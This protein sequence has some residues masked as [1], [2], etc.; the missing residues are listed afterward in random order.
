MSWSDFWKKQDEKDYEEF[1][2]NPFEPEG[3]VARPAV[4]LFS[5]NGSRIITK[6]KAKDFR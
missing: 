4:D 2:T 6:I 1:L 3:I 5:R